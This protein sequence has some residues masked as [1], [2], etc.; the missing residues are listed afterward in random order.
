MQF[1]TKSILMQFSFNLLLLQ[2][3]T[4]QSKRYNK[5]C[6]PCDDKWFGDTKPLWFNLF[7]K[8]RNKNWKWKSIKLSTSQLAD[9]PV[10]VQSIFINSFFSSV[11][12]FL[13]KFFF[14]IIFN[15]G[16]YCIR[17]NEMIK[18]FPLMLRRVRSWRAQK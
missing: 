3:M 18:S 4:W 17:P 9:F 14:F 10:V 6:S 11:H 13:F 7:E 12:W 5:M 16:T 15:F 1:E 8:N 2:T